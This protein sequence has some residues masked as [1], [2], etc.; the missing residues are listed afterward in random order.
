MNSNVIRVAIVDDNDMIR[1]GMSIS[2]DVYEDIQIVGEARNGREALDLCQ[3]LK[4]DVLLI[5][6][7]MPEMDGVTAI[8]HIR[9]AQPQV[10][11]VALTSFDEAPLIQ[12]ALAAGALSYLIKNLSLEALVTAIRDAHAEKGT[13]APEAEQ[14]L[15]DD[16]LLH[17]RHKPLVP[18]TTTRVG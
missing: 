5:D 2:L 1:F 15:D 17:T 14:A 4:P 13:V 3:R 6:L 11:C 8:R 18:G 10:R 12:S 7:I 9:K 16:A